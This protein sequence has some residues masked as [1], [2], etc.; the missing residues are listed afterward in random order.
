M[1]L[2]TDLPEAINNRNIFDPL[3]FESLKSHLVSIQLGQMKIDLDTILGVGGEG[4]V[5][6]NLII[7]YQ[8]G[9]EKQGDLRDCFV[10]PAVNQF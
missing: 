7:F 6:I 1:Y 8:K 9:L 10:L 4:T 2:D 5:N 3:L